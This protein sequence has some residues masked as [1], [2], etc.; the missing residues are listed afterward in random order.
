MSERSLP[1]EGTTTGDAG[2][3][4]SDEWR[5]VFKSLGSQVNPNEGILGGILDSLRPS[6]PGNNSVR[7]EAGRDIV[8][9][10]FYE[11]DVAVTKTITSPSVGTT[12]KR[13]VLRKSW[14][15]Q[16]VRITEISS[17]DG[18][19]TIPALTQTDLTTWDIP[20]CSFTIDTGGVISAA[21]FTDNREFT[22]EATINVIIDGAGAVIASGVKGDIEIPFPLVVLGWTLL[23][24]Q[25]GSIVID[26]W[27]DTYANYPPTV[28][29]TVT[30]TEKPTLAS[31][32]KNQ[33]L[34]LTSW[35]RVWAS[36]DI[37]RF[38]VDSA[39][40]ILRISLSIRVAAL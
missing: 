37:V 10:T 4:T 25:S 30:G 11:A 32:I 28:A 18:T 8:D 16:T 31:T 17:A 19:G 38:N 29:D 13:L 15:A 24:D 26:L 39:A 22:R 3:Y 34:T 2:P 20:L 1:W 12:G 14:A 9:G 6:S 36:G 5:L 40:T 7:I 23:A 21:A 33:D 27:K 35:N